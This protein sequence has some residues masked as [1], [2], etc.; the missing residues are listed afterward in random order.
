MQVKRE[1]DNP[2]FTLI[3]VQPWP[4]K[5]WAQQVVVIQQKRDNQTGAE[6]DS[7]RVD[8][9]GGWLAPNIAYEFAQA[10]LRACDIA[11]RL[12]EEGSI[13]LEG[14]GETLAA[15]RQTKG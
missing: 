14:E 7:V 1:E 12:E 2:L 13:L 6:I 5:S 4:D 9:G 15:D 3:K 8:Y 11:R 10:I